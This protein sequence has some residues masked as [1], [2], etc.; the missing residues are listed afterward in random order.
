MNI[1]FY[2]EKILFYNDTIKSFIQKLNLIDSKKLITVGC[3]RADKQFRFYNKRKIN[4]DIK[5][6]IYFIMPKYSILPSSKKI[7]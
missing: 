5:K 6:I 2:G 7:T 1:S 3:S 4:K